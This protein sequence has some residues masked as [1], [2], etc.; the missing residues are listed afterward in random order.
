MLYTTIF[1]CFSFVYF[2]DLEIIQIRNWEGQT[3]NK[4]PHPQSYKT[5]I[6]VLA[7]PGL[8]YLG[9]EKL[10]PGAPLLGLAKPR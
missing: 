7:Y 2:E 6:K 5:W 8:A 1:H 9:V 3:T 4:K 10:G